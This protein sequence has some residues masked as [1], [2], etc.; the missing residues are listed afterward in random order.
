MG[1]YRNT[2]TTPRRS[3]KQPGRVSEVGGNPGAG[4]VWHDRAGALTLVECNKSGAARRSWRQVSRTKAGGD[5]CFKQFRRHDWTIAGA[6]G[7]LSGFEVKRK[8]FEVAG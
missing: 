2:A 3:H 6:T 4:S 1:Q 5:R 7:K 8:L